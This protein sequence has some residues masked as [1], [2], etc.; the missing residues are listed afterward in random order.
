MTDDE[1]GYSASNS[2]ECSQGKGPHALAQRLVASLLTFGVART[3]ADSGADERERG[4]PADEPK[5]S[6]PGGPFS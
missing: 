4:R 3:G 1:P 2:S 6:S 5:D